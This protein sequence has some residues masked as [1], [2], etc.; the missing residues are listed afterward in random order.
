MFP[1][2]A[3]DGALERKMR[4][5]GVSSDNV[6]NMEQKLSGEAITPTLSL[7]LWSETDF[8]QRQRHAYQ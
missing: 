3:H 2:T 5:N 7:S 6:R 4:C 1:G 8:Y